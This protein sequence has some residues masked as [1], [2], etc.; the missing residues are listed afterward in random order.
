[1][2][3][4]AQ[5]LKYQLS[6]LLYM[7]LLYIV[8]NCTKTVAAETKFHYRRT[9]EATKITYKWRPTYHPDISRSRPDSTNERCSCK[10]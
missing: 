9:T 4:A 3:S 2:V 5:N 10:A 8:Y 7:L 6:R 1:M